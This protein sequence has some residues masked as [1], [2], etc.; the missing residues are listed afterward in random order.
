MR[1]NGG[2]MDGDERL[3]TSVWRTVDQS[4]G[5]PLRGIYRDCSGRANRY[6][7]LVA[8]HQHWSSNLVSRSHFPRRIRMIIESINPQAVINASPILVK[9][10]TGSIRTPSGEAM[11]MAT[12]RA[13]V[14][15]LLRL[16]HHSIPPQRRF[17][18]VHSRQHNRT[19][20]RRLPQ[21][22]PRG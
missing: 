6:P 8:L 2:I 9:S 14:I 5:C 16:R 20:I 11:T 15:P 12:G 3:Q 18:P 19:P 22:L 13:F 4:T 21:S 10:T 7:F 1:T 17:A